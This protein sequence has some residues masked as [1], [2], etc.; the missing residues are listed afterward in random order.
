M[1]MQSPPRSPS[2]AVY[3][4]L[5][6][7]SASLLFSTAALAEPGL[8][9]ASTDNSLP[10]GLVVVI[11]NK[12]QQDRLDLQAL[13]NPFISGV[14]LQIRWRDLEPVQGKPDW[15]KLDQLFAAAQSSKKW[16]QLLLFPGF[17]S[18]AWALEGAQTAVFPLQYGPGKGTLEK[19][20]MPWDRVYLNHWFDFLKLV[21]DRYGKLPAFRLI[22]ADGPTSVSAEFTL[23]GKPEAVE[24]WLKSGYTPRKYL[25]SWQKTFQ[26]FAA[27][28][29]NQYVSLS[30]G[31]G[32]NINDRGKRDGR[33]RKITKQAVIDEGI[34]VLGRRFVFQSSNLDGNAVQTVGAPGGTALVISY[35]GRIVTGFQLRTSC[36]R[37]SGDMGAEGDP[38]L[39]LRRSIDKGMAPNSSGRHINYLEI[40]APDVLADDLQPTL[41]YGASLFGQ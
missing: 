17:F 34:S 41:R 22:A 11:E 16:V 25:D 33:Q 2:L 35:N 15:S 6:W 4:L 18:P 9:R 7:A 39:A 5:V 38:P 40:Y 8:S 32:L 29:P 19:L 21:S 10:G 24:T 20:P 14:A 30:L 36:E 28:F 13:D 1:R 26:V 31:T 12:P 27:D 23:P 3:I 37:N